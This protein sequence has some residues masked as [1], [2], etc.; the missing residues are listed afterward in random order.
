MKPGD[1]IIAESPTSNKNFKPRPAVVLVKKPG[2]Y[3]DYIVSGISSR[4][5]QEEPEFD[6]LILEADSDFP[7][8]GLSYPGLIRLG[9]LYSVGPADFKRVIGNISEERHSLLLARLSKLF[10]PKSSQPVADGV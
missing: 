8:T 7:S 2:R 6:I 1:I 5:F 3:D 10:A 9:H 4:L